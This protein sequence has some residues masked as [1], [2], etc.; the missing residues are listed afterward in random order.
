M[1]NETYKILV[2]LP[3]PMGDA[4]LSTPALGAIRRRFPDSSITFVANRVVREVLSPCAFNDT[5]LESQSSGPVTLA[6]RLR[7]HGFTHAVLFKN[8]FASAL[9]VALAGIPSRIG[10]A[11]EGRGLFLTHKLQ[12]PRRPDGR[13]EPRSMIDYYA[14]IA[15]QLGADT[16]DRKLQLGIEPQARAG[17]F[18]KCPELADGNTL[19]AVL[20]PGGAFGASKCW[21]AEN[22]AELADRLVKNHNATVAVSVAPNSLER[23]IAAEICR[24]SKSKLVNLSEKSLTIAGLKALFAAADLVVTNDTGPRHIATALGRNVV[25]LFGPNDPAW[26]ETDCPSEVQIVGNVPCAPCARPRCRRRQHLCMTSI[27]PDLVYEAA[28]ELLSGRRGISTIFTAPRFT[29][30]AD[31]FFVAA[32]Y[33]EALAALGLDSIDAVFAFEKG[34]NLTKSNLAGY[35]SRMRFELVFDSDRRTMFMKRYTR[36]PVTVQLKNWLSHRRRMSCAACELEPSIELPAAGIGAPRVV[37]HGEQRNLLFETRSFIITEKLA[38]AEALERR[39]PDCFEAAPRPQILRQRRAF[40]TQLARLVRKFHDTG[41]CHRD[42][43]LS[44]IF[45][46]PDTG[47]HVIDLARVFKPLVFRRRFRV[48]DIAQLHYSAPSEHFSSTDRL[49]F[50]LAYTGRKRLDPR[51]K[52]FIRAVLAKAHRMA[53]HDRKHGRSAPFCDAGKSK[54]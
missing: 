24:L 39:L 49:R 43:Y 29:R 21:P 14:E 26:T 8:S 41:S 2:W 4:I 5:W 18:K 22:F 31:S 50:Y 9:T 54:L 12:P 13:Y 36:P 19:L 30:I 53:R 52:A 44:H 7:R 33:A 10:Y 40:I 15:R 45:W 28:A 17:L 48:K 27:K 25:T 32:D 23:R 46:G 20:V 51:D 35:R 34:Q 38:G 42:L 3:S 37:A 16:S 1:P 11:R 6:R 47:F